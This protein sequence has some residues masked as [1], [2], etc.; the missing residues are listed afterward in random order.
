MGDWI[1][2]R[3]GVWAS[4]KYGDVPLGRRT[5]WGRGLLGNGLVWRRET[6]S[7]ESPEYLIIEVY[8]NR[9]KAY[10]VHVKDIKII[11]TN[12]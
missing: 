4:R 1:V 9:M 5:N 11:Q 10:N 12:V 3:R 7:S 8:L 2:G 6:E